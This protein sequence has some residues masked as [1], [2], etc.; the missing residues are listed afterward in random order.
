MRTATNWRKNG[1]FALRLPFMSR[2]EGMTHAAERRM[3]HRTPCG[4]GAGVD[5]LLRVLVWA[6]VSRSRAMAFGNASPV[7]E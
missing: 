3:W 4:E 2:S 1:L 6:W 7:L 5:L